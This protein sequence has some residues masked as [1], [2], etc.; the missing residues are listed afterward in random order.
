MRERH[1]LL[2]KGMN[3]IDC[4]VHECAFFFRMG[5]TRV[6]NIR[7][8]VWIVVPATCKQLLESLQ[9]I[10]IH[11]LHRVPPGI[12]ALTDGTRHTTQN[13]EDT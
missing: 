3:M 12:G 6:R 11:P 4:H 5:H 7:Q 1:Q 8:T 9:S 2:G 13:L 10:I